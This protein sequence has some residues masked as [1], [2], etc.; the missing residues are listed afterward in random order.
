MLGLATF[1]AVA[2]AQAADWRSLAASDVALRVPPGWVRVAPAAEEPL[3]DPRTVLVVGTPGVQ[4]RDTVCQVTSYRIPG[5]GAAV[6]VLGSRGR[7]PLALPRDREQL[8][9]LRLQRE[10]FEC[11]DGRGAAAQIALR[12]RGYQVNVLVGDRATAQTVAQ[13][14]AVARSFAVAP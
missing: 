14:L 2:V 11:W 10:F 5:D 4:A 7:A 8:A 1:A 9:G 13:A 12:G 6:V 3:S